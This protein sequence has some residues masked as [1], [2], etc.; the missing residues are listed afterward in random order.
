[1]A[2]LFLAINLPREIKDKLAHLQQE[3]AHTRAQVRWVRPEGIHLTLKFF[4]EVP[5]EMI[6]TLARLAQ[7]TVVQKACGSL[8]FRVKGLGTFPS[9]RRP[10]VIWVGLEGDLS[11]LLSLQQA[12]EEAFA[13]LGFVPED[14]PFVPHLTLG[15]VKS[16][17]GLDQLV[18]IIKRYQAE[19]FALPEEFEVSEIILYQSILKP[20]GAVYTPL[21]RIP[22]H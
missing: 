5:E 20:S 11:K 4:G 19:P 14:R 7:E 13:K 17:K 6:D 1:M 9:L 15:R 3:L 22:L 8:R 10:R 12:L 18:S 16:G 2:R 21:R